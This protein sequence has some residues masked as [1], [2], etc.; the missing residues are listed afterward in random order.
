MKILKQSFWILF[1][2]IICFSCSDND[3]NT[4]LTASEKIVGSW[5]LRNRIING[6]EIGVEVC[7]L[8]TNFRFSED[9]GFEYELYIGD[10]PDDCQSA[11]TSGEYSF[12]DENTIVIDPVAISEN[13]TLDIDFPEGNKVL[14]LIDTSNGVEKEIYVRQ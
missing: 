3:E 9:G 14:E 12:E 13:T 6:E 4:G 1:I 11:S 7:E 10:N 5:E 2:G 8:Q